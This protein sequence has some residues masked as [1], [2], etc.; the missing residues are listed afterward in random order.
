MEDE[1]W[2]VE[3]YVK[4]SLWIALY[5]IHHT[6]H[7]IHDTSYITHYIS[8]LRMLYASMYVPL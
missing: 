8:D 1:R 5:G 7:N 6:L 3:N 2:K 4:S